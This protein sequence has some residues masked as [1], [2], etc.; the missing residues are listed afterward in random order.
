MWSESSRDV[1]YFQIEA[2]PN[3]GKTTVTRSTPTSRSG[4]G[5]VYFKVQTNFLAEG[6]YLKCPSHTSNNRSNWREFT[7]R[8]HIFSSCS[9]TIVRSKFLPMY[10]IVE[11][12]M[13]ETSVLNYFTVRILVI[14]QT[15]LTTFATSVQPY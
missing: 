14:L 7:L 9:H 5:Q 1:T 8:G 4:S 2:V 6:K 3:G 11:V 15:L 10:G 12:S 13:V